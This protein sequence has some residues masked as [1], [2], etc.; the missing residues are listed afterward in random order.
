MLFHIYTYKFDEWIHCADEER[1]GGD[2]GKE[3]KG[4]RDAA[5][6]RASASASLELQIKGQSSPVHSSPAKSGLSL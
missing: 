1:R 2:G 6:C 5:Q 3:R 4:A